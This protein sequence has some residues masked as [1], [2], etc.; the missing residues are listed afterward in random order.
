MTPLITLI[1]QIRAVYDGRLS[2][3]YVHPDL[4]LIC[5]DD[6]FEGKDEGTRWRL[7]CETTRIDEARL[8][9]HLNSGNVKIRLTTEGERTRAFG[10]LDEP[11]LGHHWIEFLANQPSSAPEKKTGAG[12]GIPRFIHFYGYKG[13]QARST[14][15]AMLAQS[16]ADDGYK[17][18]AVDT[19][20]EAPSLDVIFAIS[21]SQAKSTIMAAAFEDRTIQTQ[22]AYVPGSG[23]GKLDIIPCRP[24]AADFDLDFAA[25]ALRTA[26]DV[27]L[28]EEIGKRIAARMSQP[29]DGYDVVLFDHRSGVA[30]SILPFVVSCPGPVIICLRLDEQSTSAISLFDVLLKS[31]PEY[32]GAFLSFSLD[33]EDT[34]ERMR[35]RHGREIEVL[36]NK[37]ADAI[38]LGAESEATDSQFREITPPD[39]LTE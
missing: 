22:S 24:S 25:F 36:L 39:Q 34:K 35:A 11:S 2:T 17:V 13:G 7:F 5:T 26:L 20:L 9:Q 38:A 10:F 18:L 32:P 6:G 8:F 15:L 27:N 1:S 29:D 16:L 12:R 3:R 14:V 4:F 30:P 28:T 19:D 21:A 23:L 37:L 31:N 33:P